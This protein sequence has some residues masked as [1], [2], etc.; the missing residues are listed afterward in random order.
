VDEIE[1]TVHAFIAREFLPAKRAARLTATT[2]LITGGVLD[3]LGTLKLAGFLE[4]Q[5]AIKVEAHEASVDFLNT[6][7]DIARFV[8]S[9]RAGA[10]A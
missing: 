2:P 9:K 10:R 4:Q 5:F 1:T 6:V 3:S 7:A 8:R